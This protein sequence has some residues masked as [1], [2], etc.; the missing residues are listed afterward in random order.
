MA[1][2]LPAR[3]RAHRQCAAGRAR[4][5]LPPP[6]LLHTAAVV[7]LGPD[8]GAGARG[9]RKRRGRGRL[10]RV[11][12]DQAIR[13]SRIKGAGAGDGRRGGIGPD[14]RV[15]TKEELEEELVKLLGMM[16]RRNRKTRLVQGW[17]EAGEDVWIPPGWV[18]VGPGEAKAGAETGDAGDGR[19]AAPSK[20]WSAASGQADI[21]ATVARPWRGTV[22]AKKK[23]AVGRGKWGRSREA[24]PG[25]QWGQ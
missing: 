7:S 9:D 1:Q 8:P 6:T 21:R 4:A 16:K 19:I 3:A 25:G 18:F 20:T 14:R 2:G 15:A 13:I 11:N 24:I 17:T 12:V 23:G 5:A 10:P 22:G